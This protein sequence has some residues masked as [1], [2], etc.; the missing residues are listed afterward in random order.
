MAEK[1]FPRSDI[2]D[3]TLSE[4]PDGRIVWQSL[5]SETQRMA[6]QFGRDA[7]GQARSR[8]WSLGNL[9]F[10]AL[11]AENMSLTPVD[12]ALEGNVFLKLVRSG[13]MQVVSKGEER[14]F[15]AGSLLI[16]DPTAHYEQRFQNAT[17]LLS[18]KF[19][20]KLLTARNLRNNSPGLVVPDVKSTDTRALAEYML[21]I[22]SQ[23][24]ST[25][26]ALRE[27]QARHMLDLISVV[28][29][30][31]SA[32][33]RVYGIDPTLYRAQNYISQRLHDVDLNVN[34]IAS[35]LGVSQSR[36]H[37]AFS[38][39]DMSLMRYVW[40]CRLE[41]AADLLSRR[42]RT[43]VTIKEIAYRCGFENAAHF[44]RTFKD[45][46]GI[47]PKEAIIRGMSI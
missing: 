36:L 33:T 13:S 35:S 31:P 39:S 15:D 5:N 47:T 29:G 24:G 26:H 37:R 8:S 4:D 45:R 23:N 30:D 3:V 34:S 44:S 10:I 12:A 20:K 16:T 28:I 7:A 38:A 40:S 22:A 19:P 9:D 1:T 11:T 6:F 18:L 14:R 2:Y 46:F 25:S 21:V 27:A 42:G 32:V 41:R 17:E 43:K